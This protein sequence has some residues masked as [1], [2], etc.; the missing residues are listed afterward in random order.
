M[1]GRSHQMERRRDAGAVSQPQVA[2]HLLL[3]FLFLIKF[4]R[5]TSCELTRHLSLT[6]ITDTMSRRRC[7][8]PLRQRPARRQ[9]LRW[10]IHPYHSLLP[11]TEESDAHSEKRRCTGRRNKTQLTIKSSSSL[12]A[13]S[14]SLEASGS[15]VAPRLFASAAAATA[16]ANAEDPDARL[17]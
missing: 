4:R 8:P 6:T 5:Q 7:S 2:F 3:Y 17:A 15:V 16:S 9:R 14:G 10:Q 1:I 12:P 13:A 11:N